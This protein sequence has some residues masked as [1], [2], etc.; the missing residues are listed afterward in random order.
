MT[1]LLYDRSHHWPI[2][3][4]ESV[5]LFVVLLGI[6][7][8]V[9]PVT[10]LSV[11]FVCAV[12][13]FAGFI[14]DAH[15]Y[16][17]VALFIATFVTYLSWRRQRHAPGQTYTRSAAALSADLLVASFGFFLYELGRIATNGGESRA[18]GNAH[19]VISLERVLHLPSESR[20]QDA[21][22][23]HD[24]LLRLLNKTYSFLFLSTVISVLIWLYLN[25]AEAY[26][27]VR[28]AL[29]LSSLFAIGVFALYPM[30]PPRLMPASGLIDSHAR[31]GSHHGFVNQFAAMPS[32]H[33]GWLTLMGW[34]VWMTLRG[35]RGLLIGATPP[36][37]MMIAVV[38]TGNHFWIDGVIGALLCASAMVLVQR[39][40]PQ[41]AETRSFKGAP[42]RAG[43]AIQSSAQSIGA[44]F[45]AR[46]RVRRT[47]LA[48]GALLTYI[49][50]GRL[51]DPVFT[52]YWGY[53]AFQV[54]ILGVA[55]VL[56]ETYRGGTE[57]LLSWQ[58]YTIIVMAM[59][60]DVLGTA[61]HLYDHYSFYDKIVHYVGSAA[62]AAVMFDLLAGVKRHRNLSWSLTAMAWVAVGLSISIG[63]LWE[64]YEVFGDDIFATARSGGRLDTT[65]DLICDSFG[66]I[67]AG[68]VLSY[69][70]F[71]Q[72]QTAPQGSLE[73]DPADPMCIPGASQSQQPMSHGPAGR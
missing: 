67:T 12:I 22:L 25:N 41:T 32:L 63:V 61:G 28:N 24:S 40:W 48:M 50:M 19:R 17:P 66:A 30:A 6:V 9:K 11:G 8:T 57:G 10:G 42:A 29:G 26:R 27:H 71:G 13:G 4:T 23:K 2:S 35:W 59:T 69:R 36:A 72:R 3:T 68:I 56:L 16:I 49:F 47:A 53:L 18:F 55:V 60:V 64:I 37:I 21:I 14:F 45:A 33:I 58:T 5:I 39:W 31:V 52:S 70:G 7:L 46:P 1:D 34:G 15:I 38:A 43:V 44:T 20:F 54:I 65:Y 51:V 73:C 62:V